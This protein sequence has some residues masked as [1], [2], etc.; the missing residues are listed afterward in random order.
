MESAIIRATWLSQF[1]E[2]LLMY[3]KQKYTFI[4]EE[5]ISNMQPFENNITNDHSQCKGWYFIVSS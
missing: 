4:F 1:S 5:E 2:V 3:F